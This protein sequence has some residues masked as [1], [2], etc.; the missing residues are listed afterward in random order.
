MPAKV[1][2]TPAKVTK[3]AARGGNA[4]GRHPQEE[5]SMIEDPLDLTDRLER[6]TDD[7][8]DDTVAELIA[9]RLLSE[10]RSSSRNYHLHINH[11]VRPRTRSLRHHER[12]MRGWWPDWKPQTPIGPCPLPYDW[13]HKSLVGIS[14][15]DRE[16]ARQW[17]I[18]AAMLGYAVFR[19]WKRRWASG[20]GLGSIAD[21]REHAR[22]IQE[23]E[24]RRR[25]R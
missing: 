8:S 25:V 14:T 5:N 10:Y 19:S 21:V 12:T 4:A 1:T 17:I 3:T 13:Q 23:S 22:K 9:D 6:I 11:D 16:V 20:G 15:K 2:K 7:D 18:D 24:T